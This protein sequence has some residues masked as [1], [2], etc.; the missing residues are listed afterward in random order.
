M[1]KT[2]D[3][4][5]VTREPTN[6]YDRN[7]IQ[8]TFGKANLKVGHISREIAASLAPLMDSKLITRIE[9]KVGSVGYRGARLPVEL[10]AYGSSKIAGDRRL[11]MLDTP[12]ARAEREKA[13][14]VAAERQRAAEALRAEAI[15]AQRELQAA[16]AEIARELGAVAGPG[17]NSGPRGPDMDAIL[18]Q[19]GAKAVD[20][21]RDIAIDNIFT[22]GGFDPATIPLYPNPPA[23]L[24]TPLLPHQLQ[25]RRI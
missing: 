10:T 15:R 16:R 2:G 18:G 14:Q 22:D 20:R 9:A 19:Q 7:A 13:A 25:V 3:T 1:V 8:A 12:E 24:K 23:I 17:P 4:L 6:A 5:N 11:S 21:Q